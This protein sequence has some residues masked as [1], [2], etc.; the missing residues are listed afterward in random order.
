[1]DKNKKIRINMQLPGL[2]MN[3]VPR[4]TTWVRFPPRS[5]DFFF[6]LC[7][8]LIPFTTVNAQWVIHGLNYM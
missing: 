3:V 6:T 2:F 7:G 4:S 8:S 5:K 1:M